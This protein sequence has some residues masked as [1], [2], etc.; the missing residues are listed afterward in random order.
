MYKMR[1]PVNHYL[2]SISLLLFLSIAYLQ[3][4][5][6]VSGT[7]FKDFNANGTRENT[8]TFSEVGMA[9]VIVKATKPNGTALTVS[10]TGGGTATNSTGAYAVSGGTLGQIRL[11]F[12][13]P[14]DY[15]FASKG[16]SSGTT[17]MFPAAATQDLGVN[18]PS[19]YCDTSNPRVAIPCY[20]NGNSQVAGSGAATTDALVTFPYD[21]GTVNKLAN[22]GTVGAT[23]GVAYHKPSGKLFTAA[24][25][26]R[27][28]NWGPLGP[29]GIY[30]SPNAQTANSLTASSS[31]VNLNTINS[32]FNAGTVTR[33]FA[34]G[35]GDP[36]QANYDQNMFDGVGKVGL[37]DLEASE[38]GKYLYV[39][40]LNDRKLWR[41]EIGQGGTA[42]TAASQIVAYSSF[43]N[44]CTGSTFRPFAIKIY[45]GEIY[46]GGVCDGV[47]STNTVSRNNLKATIYKVSASA[48]PASATFTEVFSMPLTFNRNAN[49][50]L[51]EYNG[52]SAT[53]YR[54]PNGTINTLS[55]TSWHPWA[56]SMTDVLLTTTDSRFMYPQPMLSD[57]EFDVEG[58][59]ILGFIDRTGHQGGNFNYGTNTSSGTL[60]YA[61]SAGDILRVNNNNGTFALE[62]N[63]TAG[64]VTTGGA[65]NGDGPGGGEFYF[66]D[67]FYG[68]SGTAPYG[69]ANP[70]NHDETSV[71]GLTLMAG[72][73][74]VLN[75]VFDPKITSDFQG[76]NSGGVRWYRNSN[77]TASDAITLYSNATPGGLGKASGLGDLEAM[78][79]L[80][81]I[82]IGNRVWD[83]TD[84]DGVQD[85][86]ELPIS[87]VTVKLYAADGTTLISTAVT[88]ANGNY[89][90]SSATGTSTTSAKYGVNLAFNTTYVLSFPTTV[91]G[92]LLTQQNNDSNDLIDSDANTAGKI[93]FTTGYAGENDHSF[94]VGYFTCSLTNPVVKAGSRCGTGTIATSIT[95]ACAAGSTIHIFSNAA[96]TTDVTS[97]FTISGTSVTSPN[98][99]A[100]TTYYAACV[101]DNVSECTST[102]ASFILT[103]NAFPTATAAA[104]NAT[105]AG[106]TS[107]DD[108]K[109]TLSGFGTTDRYDY[110]TGSTYTGTDT[111]ATATAIPTGGVIVNNLPNPAVSQAYTVRIFNST[112]CYVDRTITLT[113]VTCNCPTVNAPAIADAS[114]C[115]AGTV[116]ATISTACAATAS[117]KIYSN[118]TL[119]TDVTST[120]TVTASSVTSPSISTTK[121][122]YAACVHNTYPTCKSTGDTFILTVNA[123]PTATASATNTTCSGPNSNNDGKITLAGFTTEK[124]DYTAGST[125][126]GT[127][128]YATATV[129]PAS[130][131]IVSNLPNPATTQAYTVRIFNSTGC[132]IDRTVTLSNVPCFCPTVSAPALDAASRCGTGTLTATITTECAAGSTLRIFSD[133][134]LTT[135]V[136]SQF[137]IV[138]GSVTSPSISATTTYY[139]ACRNTTYTTC[140]S[141]R[142]GFVLTIKPLPTATATITDA[143]CAGPNS[144]DNGTITLAGFTNER[145]D[146]TIGTTYTGTDTYATATAIPANG[147]IANNLTNPATTR[148]YTIRIFNSNGCYV[149]RT[150]TLNNVTCLCPTVTP[151]VI[152]NVAK[153]GTGN[154]T[155]TVTTACA[156]GTSLKI[157][158]AS[159]LATD[160]TSQFTI[161]GNSITRSLTA[162]KTYYAACVHDTYP[163]CKSTGDDFT[164][165]INDVP[166]ATAVAT[167]PTCTGPTAN[168]DGKITLA[169]FTTEKYAY[170]TGATYSGTATYATATAIPASGIIVSNLPNPAVSQDYTVRIFNANGCYIDRTVTI[171]HVD[172]NC[173][174]VAAPA[175][176]DAGRCLAGTVSTTITTACAAGTTLK[177]YSN[178]TLTT[179]VTSTFTI[180]GTNVTSPSISATKTY[181]A[182]CVNNTFTTCKS[183]ADVFVLT[184]NANPTVT[185]VAANATCSG[186]NSNNDGSITLSGFTTEK[187]AYNS[188][189]T[190]TGTATYATATVIP[191]DGEIV[192]NLPNPATSQAYTIRIFNASGCYIDRTVTLTNVTC[193]CPNVVAP[194]VKANSRCGTGTITTTITTLCAT[195]TSFKVF[196]NVG[197]TTDI[198]STFTV[199]GNTLTSPSISAT[200]TYYAACVHDTYPTCKSAA[201]AFILTVNPIPTVTATAANATCA[202]PASNDDGSIT[203]A[204]FTTEK[205]DYNIGATYTGSA[206][207][208][209]ATTIPTSGIIVN[210]LAN[211]ATS[212]SYTVRIFNASGCY[213]DRTVTLTNVVC[214]CPTVAAPAVSAA[215]R[216]DEGTVVADI[217]TAC[218]AGTSLKIFTDTGLT[219]DVTSQFTITATTVTS[220]SLSATTTYYSACVHNTYPTCKSTRDP[221][222]LT[223]ND[224]PTVTADADNATCAGPTSNNNG[225]ITLLGFTTERYDYT[226]GTTYSGTD[227]YA[228]ATAIPATGIIVSNLPNPAVSQAYTVRIFNST[229]CYVDRTVTLTNVPCQC[230]TVAA[231]VVKAANR[232]GTGTV[233]TTVTTACATGTSLKI[234]SNAT[235]TTD[236]TSTFTISGTSVTSPSISA[237]KTYYAACVH[238][239]YPTCKSAAASFILTINPLPTVTASATNATC[240]GPTSNN[241]GKITLAG[242]TTERY[243]YTTGSTYTGT[244]TYATATAIPTGGVIVSNLA[245]PAV[246]QA[247]TVRIFNSSGCYVDRTVTLTNV[248][249]LCPTV[250]APVIEDISR[251]GS[252]ILASPIT[253]ECVTGTTLKIYSTAALTTDI[254][255]QFTITVDDISRSLTATKTYY[256]ACVHDTYPTCK[257]AADAFTMTV[258]AIPTVTADAND[259]TCTGIT[260]NSDGSITLAGFTTEKYDYTLGSTYTGTKTFA[261]ATAIPASGVI[262]NNLP[263]PTASQAYTVRIFSATGACYI[264]RT[265]IINNVDCPCPIVGTP[266]VRDTVRCGTG[267]LSAT[268]TTACATGA[269]LKIF[270]TA[271]LTSDIT[272]QFTITA[273]SISRSLSLTK[274]YYAACVHN[275]YPTCK[276]NYDAFTMTIND[277]PIATA[278]ATNPTCT[279]PTANSDGKITLA[280]FTT[281]KYDYSTGS[282][283]TGTKTYSTATAIP[284]SG[285]IV[286]NLP[287]PA[288]SQAYTVRIFNASGCY[289]DRTVTINHVDCNCPTVVAP[290]VG[291]Q[292]R[293]DAG[294]LV[295]TVSTACATGTTMK[296]FS[297]STLTT[298]VTAQFTITAST[299]TSPSIS[300]TTTYYA[301]CVNN[302]FTT[303]K[304]SA[305]PIVLTI[306]TSPIATATA[307]SPTCSGPTANA[308]G[309][310]TLDNFTTERYAFTTGSTYSGTATYATATAIPTDGI[311]VDNLPNPSTATQ[312]Y[313]VRIFNSTGCFIDRT[314]TISKVTCNCPTVAAPAIADANRCG[315]GTLVN[316]ITTGCAT[317]TSLKIFSNST[318]TTDVTSTF[319]IAASTVTSPN[320]TA[321]KTYYAACV[322][323]TYPTCKSTGDAFVL[324][325]NP[326]PTVTATA[327]NTT[328]NGPTANADG[329][330]TLAG[331]TTEKYDYNIGTSYTGTKTYATATAIPANGEIVSNL[332]NPATTRSYTVRIFNASGCYID[333]TVTLTNVPCNC[334][335][336]AAPAISNKARC[337]TGTLVA[338][339]TTA[340]ATG[341][342]MKIFSNAALTTDVTAQFTITGTSVTSPSI[343][344]STT[345]YAICVDDIYTSCK[346]A[347]SDSFVLTINANPSNVT[348]SATNTTCSGP[349]SNADGTITLAG[350]T[351]EKYDYNVGNTYTGSKTYTTATAIPASG[352]IV[353]NLPNPAVS[354]T[355]TV[356]IFNS[357]DCYVDRTV[358]LTNTPCNCPT[359]VA[360]A[361]APKARCGTGTLTT[362]ITTACA[363]GTSLKIFSNAALTTDVTSTFTISGVSITS[364]SI[365]ANKTYYAACV[366]DTYTTCKSTGASFL[367]TISPLPTATATATDATCAGPTS[368]ND[369]T[370]TLAGFTTE[371]YDYTIGSTYTGTDTYA[372]AT[373]I[374]V[375]GVIVNNLPNP[376]TTQTYTVRIF[377]ST[378]CYVDRTVTLT[379]VTCLCPTVTA[380]TVT[381]A[382]RCGGGTLSVTLTTACATGTSLKIYSNAT[383][384]TDVTSQF[385]IAGSSITTPSVNVTKTYYAACVHDTYINCKS[386][387]DSFI[388]TINA[389]PTATAVATNATCAGPN[390]N[391]DGKIT[392]SGFTTE[393]YAYSLGSTYTGSDTYSTATAIP[394]DGVVLSNL[395]N[396]AV[397]QAY[398]IRIFNAL[399]CYVDRTVTLTNVTCLCPTVA[400]PAVGNKAIC[401]TGNVSVSITTACAT[402]TTL[403]IFNTSTLVTDITSQFTVT[404]S[405]ITKTALAATKTYYA[406]C[407]HDTYPTCKSTGDA[408]IMTINPLPIATAVANDVTCTGP[409]ANSDGEIVLSDFTTEAYDYTIGSTYT[410][411]ATFATATDIPAD[412]II[413]SNLPNPATSQDYTVRIFGSNGCYIDRVVTLNHVDCNCPS[414]VSPAIANK[415]RCDAGILVATV[416]RDCAAGTTMKIFSNATLTTDV[417]SQFTIT[418]TTVTSPSI[419]S[420]TTYYAACFDNTFTT[421]KSSADAFA[422]NIYPSPTVNAAATNATCAGPTSNTDGKITLSNF[423]TE[424]Y[425]YTTG[426][427]YTGS[428]NYASATAIPADGIIVSNLANP[429]VSQDYTVRIFSATGGCYIDRT[430]TL[431][432]TPCNCP[433]IAASDVLPGLRCDAGSVTSSIGIA[434]ADGTT[435]KIFSTAAL[436]TDITSQF[437]ITESTVTNPNVTTSKT[438]YAAC[439]DD[440]YP[441]CK[442]AADSFTM[443]IR[444]SPTVTASATNATC[445]IPVANSD[446]KITLAGFTD[447]HFDYTAGSTYTGTKSYAGTTAIPADGIIVNNLPNPAVSQDYTVRIFS[448]TGGCYIDRTVTLTN[449]PCQC[450]IVAAPVVEDGNRCGSGATVNTLTTACTA[451]STLKIYSTAALTTDI[452]TQFT[453]TATTVNRASATAT[454]SY[455]AACV[456]DAYPTCKSIG[457]A[458]VITIN[459]KPTATASAT[460]ATCTGPNSNS[461]GE[462]TLAGFTSEKYAYSIG[463]TYTGS[464]TTYAT[465]TAIPADGVI[466]SNLPNPATS[467]S[468]TVRI[469]NS[470]D[471]YIDRV[472]TLTNTP[473]DC[474]I[475]TSPSVVGGSRCASGVVDATITT[476]CATGTSIKIFSDAALTTDITSQFTIAASSITSSSISSTTTYHV[477]CVHDTYITCK[478][479]GNSFTLTI[480]PLPIVTATASNPTCAGS[481]VNSDGKITLAGFTTEK[482]DYNV[483]TS[484]TGSAS[485][486]TATSIPADGV[487]VSSIANPA[488]SESYTIRIF[489]PEGCY[490]DRTV[491]ISKVT[492]NCPVVTAP[493]VSNN[494]RCGSGTVTATITTACA[495]GSSMKIF[496][497]S[498]LTTDV[499]S[500]FTI[501]ASS[502]TSPTLTANKTYYAACVNTTYST[503]K[504]TGDAFTLTINAV[505]NA[506]ASSTNTTCTGLT[507]N[508]DGSITLAGFTTETYDY[509]TGSTYTGSKTFATAT[510]IPADGIIVSN[511]PNP[512]TTQNYTVR[513]FNSVGCYIDR[514]VTLSNVPCDCPIVAAPVIVGKARCGTGTFSNVP[515]STP[516]ESTASLRIF[517]DAAL[518][519]DITAQFTITATSLTS[520]S[521]S[522]T[523]IYYAACQDNTYTNCLSNKFVFPLAVNPVPTATASAS[524]A[525][526]TGPVSNLDGKI[527]LAGYT[528][529]KYDYNAG[530]TYTGTTTY[531]EAKEIPADG[532][533]ASNLPNPTTSQIYSVK[534]FNSIGCSVIRKVT[535][536]NVPCDCP[537]VDAPVIS[538]VQNCGGGTITVPV[539]TSCASGSSMKI[540]A[541]TT[542]LNEV[543]S[544]F[545]ISAS[546]LISP[547]LT[548]TNSYFA[549][550]VDNT[551]GTC[552]SLI[553][554]FTL[555]ITQIPDVN[556]YG[557]P[558]S[559]SNG[560]TNN[561]ASIELYGISNATKYAYSLGRTYSG[562]NYSAAT[563]ITGTSASI[564]NLAN[565]GTATT[566]TIRVFNGSD[567]CFKDIQIVVPYNKD[568]NTS[569]VVDAGLDKI[570]CEPTAT[571]DFVDATAAQEWIVGST[572]PSAAI[573]NASTGVVSG[574][575]ANGIYTFILRDKVNTTCFDEVNVFRSVF[576]LPFVTSCESSYQLPS[577]AGVTWSSVSGGAS[578]SATGLITGMNT[579]GHYVFGATY[580]TCTSEMTVEKINCLCTLPTNAT[581]IVNIGTCNGSTL[582]NDASIVI[583][584]ITGNKAS[585]STA[586]AT[587]FDG[588][589]YNAATTVV[590]NSITFSGLQHGKNYI[591]RIYNT[592]DTCFKDVTVSIGIKTC[593]S[594]PNCVGV[595]IIKNTN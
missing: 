324:T 548:T 546:S 255:S 400:A 498:T 565:T 417:T 309:S 540:F 352:V 391:N 249:C 218:A 25:G 110:T 43:P 140:L 63:G 421:C 27:H 295:A 138:T 6:Q 489:S 229:G 461:D 159:G 263:N 90:F 46:V 583:N 274:T 220:P 143:T 134:G 87:G 412:G 195:G 178:A 215:K 354:Q 69:I 124:Y 73:G 131:I 373:A 425:A 415:A 435:L 508:N 507:S 2:R 135:D 238:D 453:F 331:F 577:I 207:Y 554:K 304:S 61:T 420:S 382:N 11:E 358:T 149:D 413:V 465:A 480:N 364:P 155:A 267:A 518:T 584:S 16:A 464:I 58:S 129:I 563:S 384:T 1:S 252:G 366:H 236:V 361:I 485:Y 217:T 49:L 126:T 457:D 377:N 104:T 335:V 315:I 496:S 203:L 164:M 201:A 123:N 55:N 177:I 23:W 402:G 345:Y 544:Q 219:N 588:N 411:S 158:S 107:N 466:V 459:P 362:S 463:N 35:Q 76:Y 227:T 321:T 506:T 587:T 433:T 80:S 259:P 232:C 585:I 170:T 166:T 212:R 257:S 570:I 88:D 495:A 574:M 397:S 271:A 276:G 399:G 103:I 360:P 262:V 118:A 494:S 150:V 65:G 436:T 266:I 128:T 86:G 488:A 205:Y 522:A 141:A 458:F 121:T 441:T 407:V 393:K 297:N 108:G 491:S 586:G 414:I 12:V 270:S 379:N 283:Y 351:T 445:S 189:S 533:I 592:A 431:T 370:I 408:F 541:D 447:E 559:C 444:T 300:A 39:I 251:C 153:C 234:F 98:L 66:Q 172:C 18:Y 190:Y 405:T 511:L 525:T 96:L 538:D 239:T 346:S 423:T 197:L 82:E 568:C 564:L 493:A 305:D 167:D 78:C 556:G 264:D 272:S 50:N 470:L 532:V 70:A 434:C 102:G 318:L 390:S 326:I 514:I 440:T 302:T 114:R 265:V 398:T 34:P 356:R 381:D 439:V 156:A 247:Y 243:D 93:T 483:G 7:V 235:L 432:N 367:L 404:A 62:N 339:V 376:A 403:K 307:D 15:T 81:P 36:T 474:P 293:C 152:G 77:G 286:S 204:G 248:T 237:T 501:T 41:I 387:G 502:V 468:Y 303:C 193:L 157:F 394:V 591:I 467:Q 278:L 510:A 427:T 199:I 173:P 549:V 452:T 350:F 547:N 308:D 337:A 122:Y 109:I 372:T 385:T 531:A 222:I 162:T 181:Y 545:T 437:I 198:T 136:T 115:A 54:D 582:N 416:S 206:T 113:K 71:G 185:A 228:S 268:L 581:P 327:D 277:M 475:V 101:D 343:S 481:T 313:T 288:V 530:N 74:T 273:T 192:S 500:Q 386:T 241:D 523:T 175:I 51:G 520:P 14:D 426:S 365:S 383:L 214:N 589:A 194:V 535:L 578:V 112:G 176:S 59:M 344:T 221:F 20:I 477:A 429:A 478:S 392:L 47:S 537:T 287:N 111:Y 316:N 298:D 137:T 33:N 186:P 332:T 44:P 213:I 336:V 188:G 486:A 22:G 504:S 68:S 28:S 42:P 359:V 209:T 319:T 289:I 334:P 5:A 75:S 301:A 595:T 285:I 242:F 410:G 567:N 130:G 174:S 557:I 418:A 550:C 516:C 97:Q 462:I 328:C 258:N 294:T 84:K 594:S 233:A 208:A 284:A 551:Y 482:Y 291:N 311:I 105:C 449:T 363:T 119:T 306:N 543:T 329:T 13:M 323:D 527:V 133:A 52:S 142:D 401:G 79:D 83:D 26:K 580:G 515:I 509:T 261:T 430:V 182:A 38:D 21:N 572:N 341:T 146:Y 196:S 3:S 48:A 165:T 561:D 184:I 60:Y 67:S 542:L 368:N 260:P 422:L 490:V 279:G 19:D 349:T 144:N 244:D 17:I 127:K 161:S 419:S 147:I 290:A 521:I 320:T 566:Y 575:T 555:T 524:N 116:T 89:Y 211:P 9:G 428:A 571:I 29:N 45:K 357:S 4:S 562:A 330:I 560:I 94:D 389:L 375:G 369:G 256:A 154:I 281:E 31:F 322:H 569:C 269:S 120:F 254:T 24:F 406:A 471:C 202:G 325:I 455:Y 438:Y 160:I 230:P 347:T 180:A 151:P 10:Y 348:A 340:C 553:D 225:T 517:S 446:G 338:T 378:D 499:T 91:S 117:L 200:K 487:I 275:T 210:N 460:N 314:V 226:T 513:I 187:Y 479:S 353:N 92:K 472:V 528:L 125:Y 57:I 536:T 64:A 40:N 505:P 37:G 299:V 282:T 424:K 53:A 240:A 169:G 552:K 492:C 374:P 223:I 558:A 280:D 355:Y 317:G 310:I 469:F 448:S 139:A 503:C 333:R 539:T 148:K 183:T 106:P 579:T 95:T 529:E 163:T 526:C 454:R 245:N 179:D 456:S 342:S 296:I 168:S 590:G 476:A 145:Y 371:K 380:P 484:Y 56:R 451:G 443:T 450:P 246:S 99:S 512:A 32:A 409:T 253:T 395:P 231:P 534:I 72:K 30:V 224:S 519:T 593:C 442:S 473:C 396:P 388:L 132:Y 497:N 171:N 576:E 292:A 100:T 573:I 85:A 250:V 312:A 8:T 216:C 191:T